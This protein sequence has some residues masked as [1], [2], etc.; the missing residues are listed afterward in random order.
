MSNSKRRPGKIVIVSSPSGGG[1][2]TICRK[3]MSPARRRKGWRF[4]I[5]YTT[6]D[7]R[8]G[9]RNGR[10]YHFVTNEEF[11]RLTSQGFFAE[12]F[13][14]HLYK[15]GTPRKPLE[16]VLR[17]GGVMLLDVDVKGARRIKREFPEVISIFVLPPA[18]TASW[19]CRCISAPSGPASV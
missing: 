10:E 13:K 19:S 9:E 15:Y 5:S 8:V 11:D 4:S 2:T 14:V 7:P 3:L 17:Q 18:R 12:H 16:Q 1:K 6:R